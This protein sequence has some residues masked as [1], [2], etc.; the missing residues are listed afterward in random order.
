MPGS[1][2]CLRPTGHPRRREEHSVLLRP[3]PDRYA[4]ARRHV[5]MAGAG[6]VHV[7]ILPSARAAL[8]VRHHYRPVRINVWVTYQPTGG[9]PATVA[10]ISLFVTR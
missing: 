1:S 6:T 2:T 9:T 8:Q 10:F 4:F 5:D 7:T 3:G